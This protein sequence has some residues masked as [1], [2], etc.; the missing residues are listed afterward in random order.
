MFINYETTRTI[1]AFSINNHELLDNYTNKTVTFFLNNLHKE[2]RLPGETEK[3]LA[4]PV[5]V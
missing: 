5:N 3:P 1:A 4:T 2:R